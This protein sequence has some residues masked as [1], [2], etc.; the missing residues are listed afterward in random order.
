[1]ER[2]FLEYGAR[3]RLTLADYEALGRVKGPIEAA[4]ERAL[5]AA[6]ADPKIPRDRAARL[7]LLRGGSIPWL[8]GVDPETGGPRRRVARLSEIPAEARPLIDLLQEQHLLATDVAE[9]TGEVTIEPAHE[10]LLPQWGLLQ[11]WLKKDLAALTALEGVKRAAR[12]WAANGKDVLWLTHSGGRLEDVE[13]FSSGR[14]L[15]RFVTPAERDYL[16]ACRR[17]EDAERKAEQT[18]LVRERRNLRRARFALGAVFVVVM[19]ALGGAFWQS[20]PDFEA[21][22]GDLREL[23][24]AAFQ[25]TGICDRAMR[26]AVAGLPSGKGARFVLRNCWATCRFMR[27]PVIAMSNWQ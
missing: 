20:F 18:R 7:L 23:A 17:R 4:V 13:R 3:D 9:D 12:D 1:M 26:M 2:F 25:R 15:A 24:Q 6:G 5:A 22:S 11:G 14:D 16:S 10:A 19:A 27:L 8:A 21:R